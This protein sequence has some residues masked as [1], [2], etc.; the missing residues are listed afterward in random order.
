MVCL[1]SLTTATHTQLQPCGH[2]FC[3]QCV[4]DYLDSKI[5]SREVKSLGCPAF[6]CQT[7]LSDQELRE[8]IGEEKFAKCKL[9]QIYG[10]VRERNALGMTTAAG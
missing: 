3:S 1:Q 8:R 5:S 9:T 10:G 2:I 6:N 7:V 4:Y